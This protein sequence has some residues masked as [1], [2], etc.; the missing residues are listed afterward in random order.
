[1]HTLE[2]PDVVP[3]FLAWVAGRPLSECAHLINEGTRL[4]PRALRVAGWSHSFGSIMKKLLHMIPHWP[5]VHDQLSSL[6]QFWRNV[7]WRDHVRTLLQ[8]TVP[9]VQ[10]TLK[11]FTASLVKW[12]YETAA[13][14]FDQLAKLDGVRQHVKVFMFENTQQRAL[15]EQAIASCE[16]DVLWKLI[17]TV[18]LWVLKPLESMR[19]WGMVCDCKECRKLRHEGKKVFCAKASR[20]L[21][22]SWDFIQKQITAFDDWINKFNESHAFNNHHVFSITR[23]LMIQAIA[24][25]KTWF[26]YLN[27]VPW[28]FACADEPVKAQLCVD[29]IAS[30]DLQYHD[31]LTQSM[32]N[33]F[34]EDLRVVA[35]G[36][37]VSPGLRKEIDRIRT[38]P[39]DESPGEGYHRGTT[40]EKQRAAASTMVTLKRKTREKQVLAL[41]RW[42]MSRHKRRGRGVVRHDW[43]THTRLLQVRK[44][45]LWVARK[46]KPSDFY[47][48]V[49]REDKMA[50]EDWTLIV[51]RMRQPKKPPAA[52]ETPDKREG[53]QREWLQGALVPN[54]HYS[55]TDAVSEHATDGST[56]EVERTQY[57]GLLNVA[58]GSK[59]PH[60]METH[61]T[62][63]DAMR[64]AR[65][66]M[67]VQFYEPVPETGVA[68]P[69]AVVVH[70]E[71]DIVWTSIN[72][73]SH[74]D[75]F[76]NNCKRWKRVAA[77]PDQPSHVAWSLPE[78]AKPMIPL[79][80]PSCPTL[81]LMDALET[82]YRM[83]PVQ[84]TVVHVPDGALEYD[85][86]EATRMHSYYVVCLN[87][88]KYL[89]LAANVIPSQEPANF[90]KLLLRG[91]KAKAGEPSTEYA[92]LLNVDRKKHRRPTQPIAGP[93]PPAP[94]ADGDSGDEVLAPA[95][96]GLPKPEPKPKPVPRVGRR[97]A[98]SG[99]GE[100]GGDNDPGGL[101][102]VG[103]PA[104]PPLPPPRVPPPVPVEAEGEDEVLAPA[105]APVEERR[106]RRL[107]RNLQEKLVAGL[108]GCLVRLD[109]TYR[110]PRTGNLYPNWHVYC[111]DPDHKACFRTIGVSGKFAEDY[112]EIG[113][114]AFLQVWGTTH[115]DP[116]RYRTHRVVPVDPDAVA[117]MVANR[118]EE[119]RDVIT[120]AKAI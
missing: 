63:D 27:C 51:G 22:Q 32:A 71:G 101:G 110:N 119:L 26:S 93:E 118:A 107:A 97:G 79:T 82:K 11:S 23:T 109:S 38:T 52:E 41:A 90:Y 81:T 45:K 16:D 105:P 76:F 111:S 84:R 25:M 91:C 94:I 10:S 100:G 112:G 95:P 18:N 53:L 28:L 34:G 86:R 83:V 89:P 60:A 29:Q 40:H 67:Q 103:G 88:P 46:I 116:E 62:G 1:M 70:R 74:F 37:P 85:A 69:D 98:G 14:V 64:V 17:V 31:P 3:A 21:H 19:H 72:A 7:T 24:L 39:L 49:Y 117:S 20:R 99:G 55:V 80:D 54:V 48:R 6:C 108:D 114:L 102:P 30:K 104:P 35:A 78:D 56:T 92:K 115:W 36:G 61:E 5:M 106:P 44:D 96:P 9:G 57:F 43:R 68:G 58:S 77:V 65:L 15:V 120:R 4:F 59:R 50:N 8:G 87:L 12:R 47:K 13:V 66:A 75:A 2:L 33:E 113:P 42:F 73:I